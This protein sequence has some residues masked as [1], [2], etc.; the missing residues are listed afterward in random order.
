MNVDLPIVVGQV[1]ANKYRVDRAIGQGGMGVVA[2]AHHLELDQPVAIKFLNPQLGV[3]GEA[4]ERFRREA[5]AAAKVHSEH[6]VRVFDIGLLEDRTPYMVMELLEGSDLGQ[7]LQ[8]RGP[9]PLGEAVDCILQALD[10]IAEAHAAGIVHRDLKPSNLFRAEQRDGTRIIKVL[11]FGISKLLGAP[12]SRAAALTHSRSFV[13]SPLYTSPE[14]LCSARDVDTRADIWSLGAILYELLTGRPPYSGE[15]LPELCVAV[16]S[17]VPQ[18]IRQLIPAVPESFEAVIVKCLAKD[19]TERFASVADLAEALVPFAPWAR[20]RAERARRLLGP[21]V[22][23]SAETPP[24][25]SM[26]GGIR[27][28]GSWEMRVN[29][30]GGETAPPA[31]RESSGNTVKKSKV[32]WIA[33]GLGGLLLAAAAWSS[34]HIVAPSENPSVDAKPTLSAVT[35]SVAAATPHPAS[36]TTPSELAPP[37]SDAADTAAAE[38]GAPPATTPSPPASVV[39]APMKQRPQVTQ[40]PPTPARALPKSEPAE[41]PQS[42]QGRPVPDFGGRR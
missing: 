15:S 31:T 18:S 17:E 14:Q 21:T 9:F 10:A 39:E 36:S 27:A 35:A 4:L 2:A 6:V 40:R 33:A 25:T 41:L 13:G 16:L 28:R 19:R 29:E 26:P 23:E 3:S 38:P 8:Q 12:E 1:V 20:A 30:R 37:G 22:P 34:R 24:L 5:R 42:P 7:E 32:P 11:D